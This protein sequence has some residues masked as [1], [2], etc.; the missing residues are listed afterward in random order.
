MILSILTPFAM[1]PI[2][3]F[4]ST[5]FAGSLIA[6]SSMAQPGQVQA[7]YGQVIHVSS[8]VQ[9]L[10]DPTQHCTPSLIALHDKA[11]QEGASPSFLW[12]YAPVV[13]GVALGA[14][15][16][17]KVADHYKLGLKDP[18]KPKKWPRPLAGVAGA[19]AGGLLGLWVT[20][21]FFAEDPASQA[22]EP[23]VPMAAQSFLT[24]WTCAP[25]P[26]PMDQPPTHYAVTYRYD[27]RVLTAR[28]RHYPG[29]RMA[30]TPQGRPVDEIT[31]ETH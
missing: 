27:N 15:V 10:D 21:Q 4:L 28:V 26:R 3:R 14:V 23:G 20:E 22:P 6:V 8:E 17:L 9:S 5:A 11:R 12:R 2:R 24:E 13:A 30:L 25:S 7:L 19:A 1:R 18:L 29:P 16:G 31:V